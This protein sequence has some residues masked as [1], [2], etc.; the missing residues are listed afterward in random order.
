MTP[1]RPLV[2]AVAA[3]LALSACATPQQFGGTPGINDPQN[4]TGTGAV[5]GAIAGGLLAGPITGGGTGTA[6]AGAAA[7][8]II[9]AAIGNAL[10]KQAADLQRSLDDSITVT[11][12]GNQL[13]VTFPQAILFATDSAT[14]SSGSR[15]ELQK[16]AANL[17]QYP[18]TVVTVIGHT[19]NTGDAGYNFDLSS[20]RAGSV[21][22]ILVNAGVAGSRITAIGR[23]EDQ[24]VAS[25]LTPEGRAQNRRVEVVIKPTGSS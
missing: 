7:G 17:Q 22:S 6:A 14:V 12:Q 9:G 15:G 25:N 10:D 8:A 16:L 13:L 11:N 2:A 21:A 1:S 20:R 24:P 3:A 19:D 23:G 5:A 18:N 4:R